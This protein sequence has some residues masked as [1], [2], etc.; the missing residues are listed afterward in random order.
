MTV[1]DSK[2]RVCFVEYDSDAYDYYEI[3]G[4]E[5]EDGTEVPYE[6]IEWIADRYA[7]DIYQD[8]AECA[9]DRA[10]DAYKASTRGDSY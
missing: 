2:G 9:A 5:Y 7:A 1:K 4:G 6:E 10:L 3:T 8:I